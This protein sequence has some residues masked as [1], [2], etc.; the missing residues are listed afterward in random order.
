MHIHI[1]EENEAKNKGRQGQVIGTADLWIPRGFRNSLAS[2]DL[3]ETQ[4]P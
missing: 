1:L 2:L 4:A 3:R